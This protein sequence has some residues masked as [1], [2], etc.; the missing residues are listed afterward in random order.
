MCLPLQLAKLRRAPPTSLR[1]P[2]PRIAEEALSAA[3]LL[4][5]VD[6]LH[7]AYSSRQAAAAPAAAAA[8][9]SMQLSLQSKL[10]SV[11]ARADLPSLDCGVLLCLPVVPAY[12]SAFLDGLLAQVL[13]CFSPCCCSC[14]REPEQWQEWGP[15]LADLSSKEQEALEQQQQA[16][17]QRQRDR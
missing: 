7:G 14:L 13:A 5:E 4:A 12:Q 2:T 6:G 16:Q 10:G 11:L 1:L 15:S 9:C 17:R 3:P 8:S